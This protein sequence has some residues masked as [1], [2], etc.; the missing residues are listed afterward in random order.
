MAARREKPPLEVACRALCQL[1]GQPEDTRWRGAPMWH[2]VLYEVMVVLAAAL[3]EEELDRLVPNY[4]F[5]EL[6]DP[7]RRA[8]G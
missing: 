3:P 1:R 8:D 2:S 4:P 5:P 7:K 6:Y